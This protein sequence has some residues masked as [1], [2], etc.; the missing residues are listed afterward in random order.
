M[1][2]IGTANNCFVVALATNATD[3]SFPSR[4][5]TTTEPSGD[6][7]VSVPNPSQISPTNVMILPFGVGSENHTFDLRVIGW[8]KVTGSSLT[9][10]WVP[11]VLGQFACTLCTAIGVADTPVSASNRFADTISRTLGI[12]NVS[13]QIVS[14]ADESLADLI[15]HILLDA[16]GFSKIELNIDVGTATSGNALVAWL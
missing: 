12:E 1:M 16:K 4:I 8:R 2:T 3:N 6:G 9:S 14:P 7:V 5:P 10:L 13:D 15:G 11:V